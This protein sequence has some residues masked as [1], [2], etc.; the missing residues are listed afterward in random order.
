M[1]GIN[2]Y[3]HVESYD[4]VLGVYTA[5]FMMVRNLV[6]YCCAKPGRKPEYLG[7]ISTSTI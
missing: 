6:N 4:I 2:Y 5:T 3:T 1:A 7:L